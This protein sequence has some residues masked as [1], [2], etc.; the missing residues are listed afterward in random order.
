MLKAGLRLEQYLQNRRDARGKVADAFLC[1]I[2]R[3]EWLAT[4]E[5]AHL[6]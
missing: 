1:T 5:P 4:R 2:S 6:G 3:P